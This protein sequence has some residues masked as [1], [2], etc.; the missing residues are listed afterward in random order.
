MSLAC[1]APIAGLAP[2]LCRAVDIYCERTS[3][4]FDAEPLNA[5]SNV[6]FLVSAAAAWRLQTR[7]PN[8]QT[9]GFVRALCV[10][11][12]IVG[13]GSFTFHTV[14]TRWASWADVIPILVFMLG[15]FWLLLTAFFGWHWVLKL[16][17]LV[18]FF[19]VTFRLESESYDDML[20]GGAMYLPTL[21]AMLVFGAALLARNLAAG[22]AFFIAAGLFVLSF[23]ARTIDMPICPSLPIGTHY[24]WHIFNATVLYLLVRVVVLYAPRATQA[25]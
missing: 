24:F 13:I 20:W 5:V 25:K 14:A 19:A 1:P 8:P 22:R 10:I 6:A 15:Y 11:I 17:V 3:P 21:A 16:A 12:A 9:D 2:D 4:A 7:N 18:V 23:T